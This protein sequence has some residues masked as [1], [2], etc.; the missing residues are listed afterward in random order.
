MVLFRLF[1]HLLPRA[2][3]WRTT[4][5]TNLRRYLEGL[6]AFAAD[7]RTFI[8]LAY[9]DLFPS[10]TRELSQW[11]YQFALSGSGTEANRRL[12]LA[13]AWRAQ[14]GQSPDYL[15]SVIQA[16]G[17]TTIFIHE[18]WSSSNPFVARDPRLYTTEPVLGTYQCESTDPWECFEP[19]PGDSLAPHCDEALANEPGYL[20]NLDLT[21]RAPPPVPSDPT[22]W[23]YFLYF[24]GRYFPEAAPIHADERSDLEALLLRVC[25][26]QQWIVTL[27]AIPPFIESLLFQFAA[28]D[29]ATEIEA[30]TEDDLRR[31]ASVPNQGSLGGTM[32]QATSADRPEA[33]TFRHGRVAFFQQSQS[34]ASSLAASTWSVL[35]DGTSELTLALRLR[36]LTGG[37]TPVI[38]DTV[39]LIGSTGITLLF[40]GVDTLSLFVMDGV[41]SQQF[42]ATVTIGATHDLVIVKSGA[43]FEVYLDDMATAADS[44]TIA[45][46]SSDPPDQTL[47]LGQSPSADSPDAWLC[48]VLLYDFAAT[49][50]Q[51]D[52]IAEHLGRH[53]LDPT[54][55]QYIEYMRDDGLAHLFTPDTIAS[56]AW[57]DWITGDAMSFTGSALVDTLD[58][59]AAI[60][61]NFGEGHF[62]GAAAVANGAGAFSILAYARVPTPLTPPMWAF[63]HSTGSDTHQLDVS[64]WPNM[65]V[66][67][68]AETS[69]AVNGVDTD[70][71]YTHVFRG[72]SDAANLFR[73]EDDETSPA[74]N[75]PSLSV[76]QF[77][78]ASGDG[79]L[80]FAFLAIHSRALN[81]G[82]LR[83]LRQVIENEVP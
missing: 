47:T 80:S 78:I 83:V 5:A 22:K 19:G 54:L 50:S 34:L 17:F 4:V 49:E 26:A 72:A 38:L 28:D 41:G 57:S 77:T 11:E 14:G 27:L 9:L 44:G 40:D 66:T 82:D 20:V 74:L 43:D 68:N 81:E 65:V 30:G 31:I 63:S 55:A 13:G 35:H 46:P 7:V 16:A 56:L 10:T 45:S 67:R 15:Q 6:A 58:G 69:A 2:L 71:F 53:N 76:D 21:R 29:P 37:G 79:D 61:L 32:D 51:R 60:V 25:P 3:A 39:G 64:G 8:D 33:T 59:V 42:D 70:R 48:E 24:G 18:W 36:L 73:I 52:D 75:V 23:P 1:Q 62:D 12:R